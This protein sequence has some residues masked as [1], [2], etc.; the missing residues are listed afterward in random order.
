MRTTTI[1]RRFELLRQAVVASHRFGRILAVRGL[2]AA[3]GEHVTFRSIDTMD[4]K[5]RAIEQYQS[6]LS[7][8]N[9]REGFVGLAAYRSLFCP[10]SSYAEAFL[11]CDSREFLNFN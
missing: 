5:R 7:Q 10:S 11:V 8:L 2:E 3:A 9:Y 4:A 1:R 6:Q